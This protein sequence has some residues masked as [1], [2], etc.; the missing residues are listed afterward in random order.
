MPATTKV[1]PRVAIIT[2]ASAGLGA[3]AA[4]GLAA[5]GWKL[6]LLARSTRVEEV[7]GELGAI[8]LTGDAAVPEDLQRLVERALAAY[9]RIDGAVIS[10]GHPAKGA[11]TAIADADWHAALDLLLLPTL[12]LARLLLPAFRAAA[13]GAIVAVSAYGAKE[14][15]PAFPLS[16][17]FRA[18]LSAAVRLLAREHARENIRVNAV[19]PGFFDN[20]PPTAE[21]I[22]RIP[23]GRYGRVDE[24]ASAIAFLLSDE[25]S[26]IT[27]Q[28]LL[29]DGALVS[30]I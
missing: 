19:L 30:A 15:D 4:R 16:S 9:G 20:F 29:V 13:G 26:Y 11:I 12:R 5:R 22:A 23:A 24:L 1:A 17:V 18:G 21:N 3:A 2:A 27:G 8:A 14:P 7:A 10:T 6:A 28:N 25:A